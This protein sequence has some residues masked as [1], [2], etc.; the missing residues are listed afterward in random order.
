M[1]TNLREFW[2]L[3]YEGHDVQ[4]FD[5]YE[6]KCILIVNK[7]NVLPVDALKIVFFLFQFEDMLHKKLLQILISIINAELLKAATKSKISYFF[8][9]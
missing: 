8:L 7:L 5:S 2:F 6:I 9:N 3:I 1:L 4:L